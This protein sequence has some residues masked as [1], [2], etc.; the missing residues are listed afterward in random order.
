MLLTCCQFFYILK[1]VDPALTRD[2][3]F[4]KTVLESRPRSL[5]WLNHEAQ[6]L[7]PNLVTESYGPYCE[8]NGREI[9]C[10]ILALDDVAPELWE[11][12][13][14]IF[15]LIQRS[16]KNRRPYP[17]HPILQAKRWSEQNKKLCPTE[18]SCPTY[19]CSRCCGGRERCCYA[20]F[21]VAH[22][23]L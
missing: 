6:R 4:V 3:D 12:R 18:P 2:R 1:F 22:S 10:E 5:D 7:F 15:G 20:Q 8:Q 17:T 11:D 14:E 19:W 21:E 9:V 23:R 16:P 13:R